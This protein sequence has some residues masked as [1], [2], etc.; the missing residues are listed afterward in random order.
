MRKIFFSILLFSIMMLFGFCRTIPKGVEAVKGFNVEK[1]LGHW[2]EIA[3]MDFRFERNLKNTSAHYT[4]NEDGTVAVLNRGQD[5]T[6]LQ[7]TQA[8][9][10]AKFVGSN[11]EAMLKVSFFGPFYAGY[12]VILLDD[13]YRYALVCGNTPAYIWF[14]SREPSMPADI[15]EMFVAKAQSIGADTD[16]LIW[17]QHD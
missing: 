3:R 7:W 1:Y 4:L 8:S 16:Q 2:Y 5:I 10:R 9:G 15:K 17:V 11:E 13:E 6:T 12:N 14:L